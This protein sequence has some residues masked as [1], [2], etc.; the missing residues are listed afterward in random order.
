MNE[1]SYGTSGICPNTESV[2]QEGKN[3][4]G[5]TFAA[6]DGEAW[7][8]AQMI[9]A[10]EGV[11]AV[12]RKLWSAGGFRTIMGSVTFLRSSKTQWTDS[13]GNVHNIDYGAQTFGRTVEFYDPAFDVGSL[14]PNFRNN[15]VHEVGHVFNYAIATG[16]DADPYAEL[17]QA[18]GG[19]LP[20][21][22]TFR[23][24]LDP[25]PWQQNTRGDSMNSNGELYADGFL[26][27]TY[28]SFNN[29]PEG[30]QISGWFD[31]QM[32]LWVSPSNP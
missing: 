28:D 4:Y 24:G 12:D 9:A 16:S 14:D 21:R 30:V 1:G 32:S 22:E 19:T 10:I 3:V 6:D 26:N 17:G 5:I 7:T 2:I 29:E 13:N 18:L 23:D 20:S 25:Y 15:V 11:A 27:W 31:A 8:E